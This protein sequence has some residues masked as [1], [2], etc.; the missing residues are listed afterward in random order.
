[1]KNHT[2]LEK[3]C[4]CHEPKKRIGFSKFRISRF[5]NHFVNHLV[6]RN[7]N[8]RKQ[9][10]DAVTFIGFIAIFFPNLEPAK[11]LSAAISNMQGGIPAVQRVLE[12]FRLRFKGRRNCQSY[13]YQNL[14]HQIEFKIFFSITTKTIKF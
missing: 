13:F 2:K 14:N 1:M 5:G 6:C 11:R 4:N 10:M 3:S 9:T 12:V 8:S 7:P